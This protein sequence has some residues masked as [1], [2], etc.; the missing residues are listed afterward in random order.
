MAPYKAQ[1]GKKCWTTLY[2]DEVGE[3][4]ILGPE[5]IQATCEKVDLIRDR[6]KAAQSRQKSYADLKR[7]DHEFTIGDKVFLRVSPTKGVLRFGKKGKLSPRYI[8]PY[9]ILARIGPMAYRL[10]LPPSLVSV[11]DVFHIFMLRKYIADPTH[12][13]TQELPELSEDLTYVEEPVK[14]VERN[15]HNLRNPVVSYV[16]VRWRNHSDEEASRERES[17]I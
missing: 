16:K 3:R 8:G 17:E 14:I 10:A 13:L 2:W 5:L 11:H 1:Y 7:K 12:V 15:E 9:E 6:I 4:R